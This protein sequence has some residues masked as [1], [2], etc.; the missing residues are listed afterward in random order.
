MQEKPD[1]AILSDKP[2][3]SRETLFAFAGFFLTLVLIVVSVALVYGYRAYRY[4]ASHPSNVTGDSFIM[5]DPQTGYAQRPHIVSKT[6]GSL[7]YTV[8][9]DQFGARVEGTGR[10]SPE[11]V[12]VLAIG[13]SFTWGH[14]V[15]DEETFVKILGRELGLEVSNIALASYGTTTALLS[16]K[17]FGFL[18]PKVVI[19]GLIN[20][21][22]ERSVL[23]CAPCLSPFCRSVPYV[24]LTGSGMPE[25]R[26]ARH[27]TEGYFDYLGEMVMP[28]DFGWRD[29]YWAMKRDVMAL[30]GRD[31]NSINR[32]QA[33]TLGPE[34]KA[35]AFRFLMNELIG[36]VRARNAKMIVVYIPVM[37]GLPAPS[38]IIRETMSRFQD[39]PDIEYLDLT[40]T[41]RS[42]AR[43]HGEDSIKGG[44]FDGHPNRTGHSIIARAVK[45]VLSRILSR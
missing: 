7:P 40:G 19:Y 6:R 4:Y 39:E 35:E 9:T 34:G 25:I 12:D 16:L 13:G 41:F 8:Y 24:T 1:S 11:T 18:K 22:I 28:H 3:K 45:P 29:V 15:E 44:G 17:K 43:E 36:E 42:Y 23:P 30:L 20:E 14:G 27:V 33:R 2:A 37:T 21:H 5:E 10:I 31:A 32:R 26:Q 38:E